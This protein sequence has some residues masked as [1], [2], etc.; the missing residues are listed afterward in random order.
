MLPFFF[1]KSID[2]IRNF[3]I[4]NKIAFSVICILIAICIVFNLN[5][6][7]VNEENEWPDY[8]ALL[9]PALKFW[10]NP[11]PHDFVGE[12]PNH[13]IAEHNYRHVR[14]ALLVISKDVF[15]NIKIVPF[16]C[17]LALLILTYYTTTKISKKKFAGLVSMAIVLQSYTFLKYDAIAVYDIFWTLFY[18]LSIYTIYKKWYLSPISYMLSIFSKIYSAPFVIMS[19]YFVS[20][21]SMSR[22]KKIST[23]ILYCVV[24]IV[25][26]IIIKFKGA[27]YGKFIHP[28]DYNAFWP[29][30]VMW[31]NQMRF[32]FLIELT[33]LPVT[34]GLFFASKARI[35]DADSILVMLSGLL[36]VG[37]FVSILIPELETPY[38]LMPFIVF[39]AIGVGILFSKKD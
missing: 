29:S 17:S 38:R 3:E 16:M 6:L 23:F 10:P 32:D 24:I 2:F 13:E 8:K 1:Q 31:A 19:L 14:N 20:N 4:S 33:I 25:S 11:V 7:N 39:F 18:L 12:A 34:V 22:K 26:V 37:P 5:E 21:S 28:V 27:E 15:H 35:R 9:E 30:L 36:M